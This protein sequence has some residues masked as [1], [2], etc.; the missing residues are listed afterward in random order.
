MCQNEKRFIGVEIK[1][2]SVKL[3]DCKDKFD[4]GDINVN[5]G[6]VLIG[7]RIRYDGKIIQEC[8]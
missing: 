2:R 4:Y 7:G 3:G 5:S 8:K 6:D 1:L